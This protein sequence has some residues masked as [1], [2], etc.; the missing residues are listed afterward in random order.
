M[1]TNVHLLS[2]HL[3][4]NCFLDDTVPNAPL[5]GVVNILKQEM[6]TYFVL[7]YYKLL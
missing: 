6:L 5:E 3:T 2:E 1:T 4:N 7:S